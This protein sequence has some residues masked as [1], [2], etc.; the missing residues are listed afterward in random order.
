MNELDNTK[1]RI[2]SNLGD[3]YHSAVEAKNASE[4]KM[5]EAESNMKKWDDQIHEIEHNILELCEHPDWR[6]CFRKMEGLVPDVPHEA[7][8]IVNKLLDKYGK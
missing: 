7:R 4:R 3:L 2:V 1:K 8:E 5:H 6:R